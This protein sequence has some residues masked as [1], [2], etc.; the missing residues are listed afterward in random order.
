MSSDSSQGPVL[1]PDM[2]DLFQLDHYDKTCH[3]HPKQ[4]SGLG[5]LTV[6]FTEN[7]Q[8]EDIIS[9]V[10]PMLQA[11]KPHTRESS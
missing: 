5:G 9:S 1:I 3:W 10:V 8:G 4:N 7:L 11:N 6:S 2:L